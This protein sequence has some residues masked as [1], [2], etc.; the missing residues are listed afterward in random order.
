M[1]PW[2][3]SA[4]VLATVSALSA[5]ARADFP[6]VNARQFQPPLDPNGSLYLEPALTPGAGNFNGS[7]WFVYAYR[8]AVLRDPTG[9]IVANLVKNQVSSDLV[10]N[11]GLGERFAL[12]LDLPFLLY[13]NGDDN[14]ITRAVA[15]GP[16]PAQAFGDLS[17]AAKGNLVSYDTL[18]G[19]GLSTLLRFS[20]ATGDTASYLSDGTQ[21]GELRLL[22]EYSLIALSL[23][24]T[25]G[26]KL[27]FDEQEVLGKTYNNQVPWGAALVARPQAWGWDDKGRWRWVAEIHGAVNLPPSQ[28]EKDSGHTTPSSPV[29]VGLSARYAPS[30]V[31]F[32]LGVEAALSQAFGN[33]PL[34]AI[35]SI[36]WAPREHDQDHDGV[37][38]DV[39]QCPELPEDRDGFQDGDGCPDWDNDDDGVA[40]AVD[41]CPSEKED[42]DGF[43]DEDGCPDPDNDRDGILDKDDACPN[44]AGEKRADPKTNGCPDRDKDGIVDKADKCPDQPEDMDGF[45]DADGCPDLDNDKDG[46][47]DA[48][49]KCPNTPQ[50]P[51]PDP[52]RPGCPAQDSDGDTIDDSTDKCPNQ[53]ET[54]N[55]IEDEDGCPDQ[56]GKPLV[57][58]SQKGGELTASFAQ[59]VKFRGSIEAPEVDPASIPTLR[60]LALELNRNPSWIVAIG[61]RPKKNGTAE[62]QAAL[63]QSFAVVEVLRKFTNRDGV[64]ETVG[65]RA[66]AKQPGAAASGFGVLL[67]APRSEAPS[68]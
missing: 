43:Q 41:K 67:L 19:F 44:E 36:Q 48:Q 21:T 23:Q 65:F 52:Q 1:R 68:P 31:S 24:A 49:D 33:P 54:F 35:A 5:R 11:F 50:G 40:D 16:P 13:Q 38:D 6:S 8:P 2:V 3:L 17:I 45:E 58:V 56:G 32:L 14:A 42:A 37:P 57:V 20:A 10:L 25:A 64:A 55:G 7:M 28:S 59:P 29:L 22:G 27:R 61:V 63:V 53:P 66:V 51:T 39:D 60:A 62:Q 12:G 15:G 30:D 26:F 46:V 4:A 34:Q 18:G 47:P 9:A